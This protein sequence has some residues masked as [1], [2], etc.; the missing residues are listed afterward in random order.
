MLRSDYEQSVSEPRL[1]SLTLRLQAEPRLPGGTSSTRV[2]R[3]GRLWD[4]GQPVEEQ[5]FG[6][7]TRAETPASPTPTVTWS[8]CGPG[9]RPTT[10]G[11]VRRLTF[12]PRPLSA[13]PVY[14]DSRQQSYTMQDTMIKLL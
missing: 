13:T 2:S 1:S 10:S 14:T 5:R 11:P 4:H 12:H 3:N 8:S 7:M 9:T 6:T